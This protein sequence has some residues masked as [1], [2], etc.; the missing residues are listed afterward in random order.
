M[1]DTIQDFKPGRFKAV[2]IG[3]STGAPTL[4]QKIIC[5]LPADLPFPIL[6]AQ[7]L[8]PRFTHDLALAMDHSSAL[9]VMEAEDGMP[10][11]PG[12]AYLGRGRM[13]LRVVKARGKRPSL[14]VNDQPP[15]LLYKPSVD[16]LFES[17]ARVYRQGVLGIVMTGIGQDGVLGARQIV[18]AGGVVITQSKETCAVY[19]MPKAC[20]QAGL[21]SASFDPEGLRRA[22]HQLSP[23]FATGAAS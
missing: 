23:S 5:G 8:P 2:A 13:H 7:H 11:L 18:D 6:M 17:C 20:D 14:E 9:T 19:G 3:S 15:D 22:I 10:V 16:Q 12:T 4:L 1:P 21:S